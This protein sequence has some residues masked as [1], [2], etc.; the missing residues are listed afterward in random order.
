MFMVKNSKDINNTNKALFQGISNFLNESL[1]LKK[2]QVN[3][4]AIIILKTAPNKP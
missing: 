2:L 3:V 4:C 1:M